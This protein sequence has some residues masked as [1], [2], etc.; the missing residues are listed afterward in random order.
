MAKKPKLTDG[1]NYFDTIA[2]NLFSIQKDLRANYTDSELGSIEVEARI[3]MIVQSYR[4]W[5]SRRGAKS[6]A[7]TDPR[8][9]ALCSFKA[10][11]EPI[12]ARQ[13]QAKL[14]P[15]I[16]KAS[17][18]P[19]EVVRLDDHGHRWVK[20]AKG[21]VSIETKQSLAQIN[22]GLLAHDYDVRIN[23]ASEK[24]AAMAGSDGIATEDPVNFDAWVME[25]RK[26][27][28]SYVL[29]KE[30]PLWR[31]DYTE[32][33]VLQ[34]VGDGRVKKEVELEFELLKGESVCWLMERDHDQILALTTALAKELIDL[35]DYCIPS[36]TEDERETSL[37]LVMD[38]DVD[39]QISTLTCQL[40]GKEKADFKDIERARARKNPGFD[41]VG[42]MPVNLTRQNLLEVQSGDYFITEKSD[43]VRFLLYVIPDPRAG[44][45]MAVFVD[46]SKAVFK[47]RGSDVLG[48]A[49]GLG[50]VLDGELVFNRSYRENVFLVFDVLLWE[51]EP[52]LEDLFSARL[53]LIR[54]RI[55]PHFDRAMQL[56]GA[57]SLPMKPLRLVR[58][59]FVGKRDLRVL[60][61]KMRPEEG[62]RVFYDPDPGQPM[63]KRHHKSDG[64][65]F[66]PN[67]RYV[68]S[69]HYDLMKWKWAELRSIDL[70]VS[71]PMGEDGNLEGAGD[72]RG[73][74]CPIYL[75]C[76]G[77]DGTHINCTLRGGTNVGLGA[78]DS[79][80]LLADMEDPE[81][82]DKA[83][84]VVEVVYDI[85]VGKWS[86]M[87]IRKDKNQPNFIDS[88]MGVFIEQA[89]S[90]SI[91][92]LEFSLNAAA[93]GLENNFH[94]HVNKS[95]GKILDWQR[96]VIKDAA[97]KAGP[98]KG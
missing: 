67:A 3:G 90:I 50:T 55:M 37:L 47:F 33:E 40:Q 86:Y 65:I 44:S 19:L 80:R 2:N 22:M 79:Y 30:K 62:E 39:Y 72:G 18:Q 13:L 88:V 42:T 27:R 38:S 58:K 85:H 61:G 66:Q 11:I 10:G 14:V 25:R 34:R 54:T 7:V 32:V 23:V 75:L 74:D 71:I 84:T 94:M 56:V 82:A 20:G 97:R 24:P 6:I 60:L 91:E 51:H 83:A 46:R 21:Q 17:P 92:E 89:E 70:L 57:G 12:F 59:A 31:L 36:E 16:F 35:L 26:K 15:T 81:R 98:P 28:T 4:R 77:P 64:L 41:F 93:H 9:D 45:P 43:G 76:A 73:V 8:K 96:G 48:Q 52:R 5:K 53:E 49:L 29:V 78:F 95:K 63:A 87:H 69:R 1:A 68:F